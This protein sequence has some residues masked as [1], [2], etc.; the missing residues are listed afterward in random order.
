MTTALLTRTVV[1]AAYLVALVL[2]GRADLLV[3]LLA[4]AVVALW[5]VSLIRDRV[6]RHHPAA[7]RIDPAT[8][9]G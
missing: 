9:P 5:T 1:I 6:L 8:R 4:A 7:V 3:G 2:N